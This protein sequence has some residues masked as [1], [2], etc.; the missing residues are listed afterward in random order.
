MM[1]GWEKWT[2]T[3]SVSSSTTSVSQYHTCPVFALRL[4]WALHWKFENSIFEKDKAILVT[5]NNHEEP[6]FDYS[7]SLM[8]VIGL[9]LP[10]TS[11]YNGYK[12]LNVVQFDITSAYLHSTFKEDIYMEQPEGYPDR[13]KRNWV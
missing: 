5:R 13:R 7:K 10:R 8:P 4:G 12:R 3:Y 1:D 9:E 11:L 6:G 2:S